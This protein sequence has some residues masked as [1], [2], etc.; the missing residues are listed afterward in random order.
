MKSS[1]K[2][3]SAQKVPNKK[4]WKDLWGETQ[5]DF[6]RQERIGALV[7]DVFV[8]LSLIPRA[9]SQSPRGSLRLL[10]WSAWWWLGFLGRHV[11][12][13]YVSA[14]PLHLTENNL[15]FQ[16][17]LELFHLPDCLRLDL[18]LPF[19]VNL[20]LDAW[21]EFTESCPGIQSQTLQVQVEGQQN[22]E[23]CSSQRVFQKFYQNMPSTWLNRSIISCN[24]FF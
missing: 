17:L 22:S 19:S 12:Q 16:Q 4:N 20:I 7:E 1:G 6:W 13:P 14:R 21:T 10:V 23:Q 2:K 9:F 18:L 5:R 24:L 8:H 11:C 15:A 3:T